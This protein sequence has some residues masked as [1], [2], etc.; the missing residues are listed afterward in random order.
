[1]SDDMISVLARQSE[2]LIK[3]DAKLAAQAARIEKLEAALRAWESAVRVDVLMEGPRYMGVSRE[4]GR[5]AWE[6]TRAA[7]EDRG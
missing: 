6:L 2:E 3:Q 4:A 1:M 5:R 7:L